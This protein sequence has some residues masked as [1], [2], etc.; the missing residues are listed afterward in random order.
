MGECRIHRLCLAST[1]HPTA[2]VVDNP[3]MNSFI[4][5]PPSS[6]ATYNHVTSLHYPPTPLHQ[7]S[8]PNIII[9]GSLVSAKHRELNF[10]YCLIASDVE[11]CPKRFTQVAND[12]CTKY[13]HTN[14][15]GTYPSPSESLQ[16]ATMNTKNQHH[17]IKLRRP[18]I[19][20]LVKPSAPWISNMTVPQCHSQ[21]QTYHA[22]S[23]S[24]PHP[25]YHNYASSS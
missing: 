13:L 7:S 21:S 18:T 17:R 2:S 19:F 15:I 10:K 6:S 14:E 12:A 1:L 9:R 11:K 16:A 22:P 3:T 20:N 4:R 24:R 8:H 5:Y 23:S 25:Q